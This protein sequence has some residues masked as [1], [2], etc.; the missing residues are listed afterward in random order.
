[1][2]VPRGT[3]IGRVRGLG[4][5]KEGAHHWWVQRLSAVSN[6]LLL[7]WFVVSL[8]SLPKIDHF[9]MLEWLRQPW[10]AVPM[11]LLSISLFYHL[12]LGLQVVI[13]DYIDG[14][15]RIAALLMASAFAIVGGALSIFSILT[16]A[17]GA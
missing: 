12:R 16:I 7:T 1:M 17:F 2:A 6:L 11:V 9:T 8:V 5:A 14:G 3:A 10:V 13:E 4:S 15:A